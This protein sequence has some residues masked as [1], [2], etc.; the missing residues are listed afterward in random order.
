[1]PECSLGIVAGS[2]STALTFIQQ[3]GRVVRHV[4]GKRA[5]FVN[6]YTPETQEVKWMEKRMSG[7]NPDHIRYVTLEEFINL[8]KELENGGE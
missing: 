7:I 5:I 3:L 2:N 8:F 4:P 6:L 1:M